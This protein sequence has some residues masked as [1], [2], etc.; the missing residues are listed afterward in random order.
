M[1]SASGAKDVSP[2]SGWH[3]NVITLQRR[4]CI[5]LV[6][7]ETRFPLFIPCLTKPD[8]LRLDDLF[9][10]VLMNTLMKCGADHM[11]LDVIHQHLSPLCID[12]DCNRSVQ[13]TMNQMKG[14]VEHMLWYQ[15]VS[16]T[17]I[18]GPRTS[19]WLA[20]R[21]CTVKGK[22]DCIWPDKAMLNLLSNLVVEK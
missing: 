12:T 4:N 16:I 3:G 17:D 6:H 5:L 15:G 1:F 11:Q 20:N 10:D 19:V 13:G 8:F 2:L 18:S 21:P 14:D 7:D 9:I 22:K